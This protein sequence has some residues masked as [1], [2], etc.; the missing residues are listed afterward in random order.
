MGYRGALLQNLTGAAMTSCPASA[1]GAERVRRH[2]SGSA[3]SR[4]APAG[5]GPLLKLARRADR[6][7]LDG[8]V[9]ALEKL[10]ECES[11]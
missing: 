10:L 2:S 1:T 9:H 3:A 7:H 5:R 8:S 4:A 6:A 11:G